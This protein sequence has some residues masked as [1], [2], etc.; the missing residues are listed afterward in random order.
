MLLIYT[1][2]ITSRLQYIFDLYFP[3]LLGVNYRLTSLTDEFKSYPGAKINYSKS[4]LDSGLYIKSAGILFE[5]TITAQNIETIDVDSSPVIFAH[6]DSSSALPFD[7]FAAAFYLVTRYEEYLS[8]KIDKYDRFEVSNSI[9]YQG[10]FLQTPVVNKWAI[11]LK[12]ILHY[13]YPDLIFH[14]PDYR[15]IPTID[16]DHAYAYKFRK[17]HRI[18]GSYGRS[19]VKWDWKDILL[20]TEVLMGKQRDP[21]DNYSYLENIH[22]SYQLKTLYFVLFAD[23]GGDDNNVTIRKKG[24]QKLLCELDGQSTV[25]IHPSLSSTKHF[26]KLNSEIYHLA[27]VLHRDI[28]ISRQ[29]FLKIKL[30]KTY[31]N[32]IELGITDDYSMG[33]ASASGFRAGIVNPFF[34]FDL[35]TNNV[36]SLRVHP[37]SI[38]DV[39]LHDY[40]HFK[41]DEAIEMILQTIK[42]VKSVH[43]EFISV[44]HNESLSDKGRWQGWRKVYE[45][46]V[47]SAV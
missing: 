14:S 24:F 12:G 40:Y 19:V 41:P 36:T 11:Q 28:T 38:M 10:K 35:V 46:M 6:S 31:Q 30:P 43:G 21:Y 25:G 5:N 16:I 4:D 13:H 22:Q 27:K 29:H 15:F 8:I 39:T 3:E 34:F 26:S 2:A 37:I 1:P 23:Y 44:W 33:Y 7:P 42:A 47:K 20:R 17:L 45:E 18:L 9:A 32:L